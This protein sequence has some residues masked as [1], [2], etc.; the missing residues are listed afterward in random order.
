MPDQT[1]IIGIDFEVGPLDAKVNSSLSKVS[2][3]ANATFA[4]LGFKLADAFTGA[5]E[6]AGE[7]VAMLGAAGAAGA[8]GAITFG[9]AGLNSEIEKTKIG[10]ADIFTA[11][12]VTSNLTDGLSMASGMMLKIR[13]DA[14]ALPG[15]TADLARIFK[16][17]SIPGLQAGKDTGAIETLSANAMAYGMGVANLD[18]GTVSR[19]LSMLLSG[20]AGAHNTLGLQLAGLG[21]DKA[22][23]FNQKSGSERFEYLQAEFGKHAGSIDL[24]ANSFEGLSSTLKDNA[25][26][27]LTS[28]TSSLFEKVKGTLG[29]VNKWFDNN[30]GTVS[31]WAQYLGNK[32]AGAWDFGVSA[33]QE[34]WP[35]IETFARADE[36]TIVGMWAKAKPLVEG[37]AHTIH[38]FLSDPTA[39]NH[40][41]SILKL[42]AAVKVGSL[43][44]DSG[45]L[46]LLGK[47]GSLFNGTSGA[48]AVA[49]VAGSGAGRDPLTGRFTAGTGGT[50]GSAAGALEL[51]I[52]TEALAAAALIAIPV[53]V[54]LGGA[55]HDLT[56]STAT[57]HK[58]ATE[59]ASSISMH[60]GNMG[61]DIEAPV[62]DAK[63]IMM[64]LAD[65]A[66]MAWLASMDIGATVVNQFTSDLS[67]MYQQIGKFFG[68]VGDGFVSLQTKAE[69]KA[70]YFGDDQN[71]DILAKPKAAM[72][73][74]GGAGVHIGTQ[75]NHMT[76][77][78][79]NEPSRV[80]R[81]A[82]NMLADKARYPTSSRHIPNYSAGRTVGGG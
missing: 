26:M 48:A 41:E 64:T 40:V 22:K 7:L 70:K 53:I 19:E 58:E 20:R 35:A 2:D 72:G 18:S 9:V 63:G 79:N 14:A 1:Y 3:S 80:A 39:F 28:A 76:V 36:E 25:K 49:G 10:L 65:T 44:H 67:G 68:A 11:N 15:E 66:G 45:A 47:A 37:V 78:S 52:S 23:E 54:T 33:I 21:G 8:I 62:N 32:L 56:D 50:A 77:S 29:D 55:I 27:F 51:G 46:G 4:G 81:L 16:L 42:Y 57:F 74:G 38:G 5:V 31:A 24:F 75:I 60:F 12:G 59:A 30:Q 34:W 69:S 43:V 17:A 73:A 13:Q 61:K 82:V 6:K 71:H